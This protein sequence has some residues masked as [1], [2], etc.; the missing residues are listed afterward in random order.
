VSVAC[1]A[2]PFLP[3]GPRGLTGW[4]GVDRSPSI[5]DWDEVIELVRESR[6]L[7]DPRRLAARVEE[8]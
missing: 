4:I 1:S 8:R 5:L 6:W 7:V 2:A 3:S